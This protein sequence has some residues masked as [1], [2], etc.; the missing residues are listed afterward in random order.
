MYRAFKFNKKISNSES[1]KVVWRGLNDNHE[2]M[3]A[4]DGYKKLTWNQ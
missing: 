1:V 4:N 2:V 3:V